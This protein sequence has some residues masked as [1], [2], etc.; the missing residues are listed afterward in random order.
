MSELYIPYNP[1]V[2]VVVNT[3]NISESFQKFIK[4][5][6][7]LS[8][9]KTILDKYINSQIDS[10]LT[11]LVTN[12]LIPDDNFWPLIQT[13]YSDLNNELNN[14][15]YLSDHS[16]IIIK[17]GNVHQFN[18]LNFIDK[19]QLIYSEDQIQLFKN[20]TGKYFKKSDIDFQLLVN[21]QSN[22]DIE[23]LY[24]GIEQFKTICKDG[25]FHKYKLYLPS[26]IYQHIDRKIYHQLIETINNNIMTILKNPIPNRVIRNY[27]L[28][29]RIID[30]DIDFQYDRFQDKTIIPT[31][32]R[33]INKNV[34]LRKSKNPVKYTNLYWQDN[35]RV[36]FFINQALKLKKTSAPVQSILSKAYVDFTLLRLLAGFKI[37]M[38]DHIS[39]NRGEVIDLSINLADDYYGNKIHSSDEYHLRSITNYRRDNIE[40]RGYS[41]DY[42]VKELINI[43]FGIEGDNIH[44][45]S[46]YK[47]KKRLDR[48]FVLMII[49]L[50]N[51][52]LISDVIKV[53]E[54]LKNKLLYNPPLEEVYEIIRIH[55]ENIPKI[56]RSTSGIFK[57]G[58]TI[59]YLVSDD[60][61]IDRILGIDSTNNSSL[62]YL[63]FETLFRVF[64][65]FH[66]SGLDIRDEQQII[67]DAYIDICDSFTKLLKSDSYFI[68]NPTCLGTLE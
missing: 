29:K 13:I 66:D 51:K 9:I 42:L 22:V 8:E 15:D 56:K 59:N 38:V 67:I 5:I 45:S 32:R 54:Y 68:E 57:L 14:I 33:I 47:F 24:E 52:Y 17:G 16:E 6:I 62:F 39:I 40:F 26:E 53:I 18:Y 23:K 25:V 19:L 61:I 28:N 49:D 37:K 11:N 20:H 21:Y 31:G 30:I 3:S 7:S 46:G 4:G 35:H 60:E 36:S 65:R 58:E 41:L 43:L 44:L 55:P 48:L 10:Q 12:Y 1:N 27:I 34:I 64:S 50:C 63:F 2:P